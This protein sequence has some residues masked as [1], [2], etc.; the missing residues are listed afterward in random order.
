MN[1]RNN[2]LNNLNKVKTNLKMIKKN[3]ILMLSKMT[4]KTSKGS[5]KFANMIKK[6]NKIAGKKVN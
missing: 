5:G 4:I 3:Q 1:N 2:N 6:L